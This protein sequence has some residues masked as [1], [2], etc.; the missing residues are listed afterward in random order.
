MKMTDLRHSLQ[1]KPTSIRLRLTLWN[2]GILALVLGAL[3]VAMYLAIH[4][5]LLASMDRRLARQAQ[6]IA[7]R[8]VD[9]LVNVE[10][11]PLP[12]RRD[13][14]SQLQRRDPR[15][16]LLYDMQGRQRD[17]AWQRLQE[18]L[19]PVSVSGLRQA[20]LGQDAYYSVTVDNQ[21][22]RVLSH[23]LFYQGQILG[24][25]Q[26]SFPLTD[27]DELLDDLVRILIVLVPLA[28]LGAGFG[29]LFLTNRALQPVRQIN[30]A[31]ERISAEALDLRLPVIGNDEFAHLAVTMNQMLSRLEVAFQ[32]M[33]QSIEQERRF[34][35]DASH[36][37]RTPLSAI[38]ANTSLA[39][40][41]ERTPEEYRESL[42]AA[43]HAADL[44]NR[45]I[46]DLLFLARSDHQ[47]LEITP[48]AVT[49][50]TLVEGAITLV[51][52]GKPGA[53]VRVEAASPLLQVWGD[54]HHLERLLVNLLENA[55]RYTPDT[56]VITVTARAEG[57]R[58]LLIVA[59][60]GE[61][62]AP[63][64]LPYLGE[65]FYRADPARTRQHGGTGLGLAICAGIVEIHQGTMTIESEV[66]KGTT[67]I[68]NLP[69]ADA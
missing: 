43:D 32:R 69:A 22:V 36:E 16:V 19:P 59:D 21:R 9:N 65:R 49:M 40:R 35:A 8:L 53:P 5:Y 51:A 66:G 61:G 12:H 38:K 63:E 14:M 67:V 31:A 37:L 48:Q 28:L 54:P 23:P 34:T 44:M 25:M 39:L 29:G 52:N 11:V 15:R 55:R 3:F 41:R 47:Q 24:V 20:M 13:D 17:D 7:H 60:T 2:V 33:A 42:R 62:I 6:F 68:V 26:L 10:R 18:T 4:T 58:V 1:L 50:D 64:H 27:M 46:Q 30:H 57:D 45:L 56:G